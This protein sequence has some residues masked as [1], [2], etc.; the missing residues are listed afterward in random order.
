[1][2]GSTAR[3][4]DII[5]ANGN[6]DVKLAI[7][8]TRRSGAPSKDSAYLP[9]AKWQAGKNFCMEIFGDYAF[10][11]GV[12]AKKHFRLVEIAV[13]AEMQGKGIGRMMMRRLIQKCKARGLEKIT[14]R[15]ARAD[16][17]YKFYQK[18]GGKIVGVNG[19]DYEMEIHL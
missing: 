19:D 14:L 1:M 8:I 6:N 4:Q 13:D 11:A 10:Y 17:A 3:V 12:F 18:F 5:Q 15:T 7:S 2:E 9:R 16:T